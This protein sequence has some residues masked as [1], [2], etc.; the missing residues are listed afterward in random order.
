[1][2]RDCCSLWNFMWYCFGVN[3]K[4][5]NVLRNNVIYHWNRKSYALTVIRRYSLQN[6]RSFHSDSIGS[7]RKRIRKCTRNR[8]TV[9]QQ[10]RN[11]GGNGRATIEQQSSNGKT[12]HISKR[13]SQSGGNQVIY[14]RRRHMAHKGPC[15][16]RNKSHYPDIISTRYSVLKAR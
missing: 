8:T 6:F 9:E 13:V 10:W 14:H 3:K 1:M 15:N 7:G 2:C 4:V 11:S 5:S 12:P 16:E